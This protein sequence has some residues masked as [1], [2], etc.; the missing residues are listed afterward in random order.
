MATFY[1]LERSEL[2]ICNKQLA[3]S[4]ESYERLERKGKV[5][6]SKLTILRILARHG[7]LTEEMIEFLLPEKVPGLHEELNA[8]AEYGLILKQYFI[9]NVEGE[10]VRTVTFYCL[11]S[12]SPDIPC[13]QG[14][15]R[16]WNWN[17]EL[18]IS[19]AM[20][21]LAFMQFH[22]ALTHSVPKKSIQ[23]YTHYSVRGKDVRGRYRLKSRNY[24]LGYSHLFVESV[25]DFA[26]DNVAVPKLIRHVYDSYAFSNDKMPWFVLLCENKIQCANLSRK[27]KANQ[28][29]REA[30][31]F[32]LLD[33]D[34]DLSENPLKVLE[35]YCLEEET[36]RVIGE[37]YSIQDWF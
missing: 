19:E 23:S 3:C 9:G 1:Y 34:F 21:E 12:A 18:T 30:Q 14:I 11:P 10:E 28:R 35:T 26:A 25:R 27:L 17:K 7:L 15:K 24:R 33:T 37:T 6:E 36:Q 4:Q 32:Y 8:L 2:H 13:I 16:T 22:I 31:V 5:G 29:T 20:S